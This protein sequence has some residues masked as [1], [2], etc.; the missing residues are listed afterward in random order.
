MLQKKFL[1]SRPEEW[2]AKNL[3][4]GSYV[5][6]ENFYFKPQKLE[7]LASQTNQLL[8]SDGFVEL[9][10]VL[11]VEL[12]EKNLHM[13]LEKYCELTEYFICD[14]YCY[15][16]QWLEKITAQFKQKVIYSI[17]FKKSDP[18]KDGKKKGG[19]K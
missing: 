2:L 9:T 13:F 12:G 16:N 3:T 4:P 11:P 5:I 1:V 17:F 6:I 15:S 10:H 8:K 7:T 14:G 19:K 18:K